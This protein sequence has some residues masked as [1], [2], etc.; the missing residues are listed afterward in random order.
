MNFFRRRSLAPFAAFLALASL[1]HAHPGHDGDHEVTWEFSH[2][3][4]HPLA[5]LM[6][7]AVIAAGAGLAWLLVRRA[8]AERL[9]SLRGSQPKR[10]N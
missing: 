1:A 4:A 8:Q 2:L 5:T 7:L 3:V 6:C 10:G 9:Q